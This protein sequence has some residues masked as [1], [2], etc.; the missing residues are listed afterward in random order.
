MRMLIFIIAAIGA[1]AVLGGCAQKAYDAGKTI[2]VAG[3][4][5]VV[6]NWDAL[7]PDVQAKLKAVDEIATRYDAAR[8]TLKPAVDAAK[9]NLNAQ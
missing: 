2:Y 8:E 7:P 6:A 1:A 9:K 4:K 5:V 3:K